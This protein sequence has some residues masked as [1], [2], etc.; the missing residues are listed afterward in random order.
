[1]SSGEPGGKGD[2]SLAPQTKLGPQTRKKEGKLVPKSK[3]SLAPQS[4]L[5]GGGSNSTSTND[6]KVMQDP[7]NAQK[8][9][10]IT[11]HLDNVV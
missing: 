5:S 4:K 3:L 2:V 8:K 1:M 9:T 6:E 11:V 10:S 7:I